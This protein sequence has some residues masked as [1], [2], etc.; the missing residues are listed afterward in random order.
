MVEHLAPIA[1][2][3]KEAARVT[4]IYH[5]FPFM[6][7]TRPDTAEPDTA[8]VQT[9]PALFDEVKTLRRAVVA[10]L[11]FSA[12][13]IALSAV[14]LLGGRELRALDEL[15]LRINKLRMEVAIRDAR[16]QASKG[17]M[18]TTGRLPDLLKIQEVIDRFALKELGN[19]AASE[20]T[21]EEVRREVCD[22]LGAEGFPCVP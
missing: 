10:M 12:A 4:A 3:K 11:V 17:V 1:Q 14:V 20:K 15:T 16:F 7:P 9:L 13:S 18:E 5:R 2:P 19:G 22:R 8:P 21:S 6:A